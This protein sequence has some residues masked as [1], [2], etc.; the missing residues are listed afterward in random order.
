MYSLQRRAK[1]HSVWM[2]RRMHGK[3]GTGET[4][5]LTLRRQEECSALSWHGA[6]APYMVM[7][8]KCNCSFRCT[9]WASIRI[10][11]L[12][13][14]YACHGQCGAEPRDSLLSFRVLSIALEYPNLCAGTLNTWIQREIPSGC[15]RKNPTVERHLR[16]NI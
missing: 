11:N 8:A 16:A 4:K 13:R 6:P 1:F 7:H 12:I 14:A 5:T 15:P 3:L 10:F 9:A 2:T